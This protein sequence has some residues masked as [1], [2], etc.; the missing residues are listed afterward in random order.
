[1]EA[2]VRVDQTSIMKE[3][4]V[5]LTASSSKRFSMRDGNEE[6]AFLIAVELDGSKSEGKAGP[7]MGQSSVGLVAPAATSAGTAKAAQNNM[8]KLN[9]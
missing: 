9:D 3:D 4:P 2:F 7:K 1:M 5:L 8:M 6:M